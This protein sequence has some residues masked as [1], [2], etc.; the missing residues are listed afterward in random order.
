[1][2]S[3]IVIE[4]LIGVG[5]TSLCRLLEQRW[6]ARLVL[7]PAATNPFLESYYSDP[8]R[9]AFPV[10][11]FYLYERW[12]QQQRIVQG[13][14]FSD[15]VVSDYLFEKDQLF[16]EKTLRSDELELYTAFRTAL[17]EISPVPDLV[18]YLEAPID[19]LM[20]RI[21]QRGAPGEERIER[22]YLVDLRDRYERLWAGWTRCPL[23][24][25]DNQDIDYVGD[26]AAAQAIL[27]RLQEV[28]NSPATTPPGSRVDRE[29]PSLFD[30]R[31]T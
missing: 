23:L 25:I 6:Q 2:Q 3:F 15:L 18:V 22:D 11:M 31:N 12:Q 24:R 27:S 14:L 29:G 19:V 26:A 8:A 10:Q 21:A 16:A 5:K 20:G 17:G 4:G 28:L 7:E 13:D 1:M 9:F 30:E